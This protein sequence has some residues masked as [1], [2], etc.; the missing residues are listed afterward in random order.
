MIETTHVKDVNCEHGCF[1][2][3]DLI[4][5]KWIDHDLR[6][7]ELNSVGSLR[8]ERRNLRVVPLRTART[9]QPDLAL[10]FEREV[11]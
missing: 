6:V 5:I 2:V 11:A 7:I 9:T 8:A 3:D 4:D 1:P 10:Y